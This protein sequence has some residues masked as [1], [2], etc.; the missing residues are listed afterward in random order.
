[1]TSQCPT[2]VPENPSLRPDRKQADSNYF[3]L[4]RMLRQPSS[5]NRESPETRKPEGPSPGL[6]RHNR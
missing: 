6:P 5:T 1:M 4:I 2:P 3:E